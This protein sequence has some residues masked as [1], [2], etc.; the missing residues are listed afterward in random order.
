M[1][2]QWSHS[3]RNFGRL[4]YYRFD[5]SGYPFFV[6]DTRTQRY[7]TKARPGGEPSAGQAEPRSGPPTPANWISF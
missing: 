5:W 2:Y 1:N 7:K 6:L 3:P 4:F